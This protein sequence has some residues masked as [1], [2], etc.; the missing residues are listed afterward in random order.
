MSLVVIVLGGAAVW[1]GGPVWWLRPAGARAWGW[2]ALLVTLGLAA[3][4]LGA[5]TG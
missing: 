2:G 4:L 3:L 5:A 1:G